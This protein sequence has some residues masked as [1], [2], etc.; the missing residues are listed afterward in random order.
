MAPQTANLANTA[1]APDHAERDR[2]PPA[3]EK[4]RPRPANVPSYTLDSAYAS[5][6]ALPHRRDDEELS[7]LA[8]E[9]KAT[10]TVRKLRC[11]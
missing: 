1:E 10:N 9:E 5:V 6:P 4:D 3:V 11:E 7:R 8:K 2:T